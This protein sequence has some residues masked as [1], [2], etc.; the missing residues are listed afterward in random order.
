MEWQ[1]EINILA[2][3]FSSTVLKGFA[4]ATV[5]ALLNGFVSLKTKH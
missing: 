3:Y 4:E 2:R 1:N 5:L